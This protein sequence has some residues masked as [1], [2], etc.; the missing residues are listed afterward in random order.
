VDSSIADGR[1][2]ARRSGAF[3]L[4]YLEMSPEH[5]S[6]STE[7]IG[8]EDQSGTIGTQISFGEIPA[9]GTAYGVTAA[10]H[11]ISKPPCSI[12]PITYSFIDI[13]STGTA[14]DA[15][16]SG[17]QNSWESD[18]GWF[19][20]DISAMGFNWYGTVENTISV[21]T[22]GVITFGSAHFMYGGSE[23]V[24]CQGEEESCSGLNV[25]GVLAV[26]WA[27][28]N[29][30]ATADS[31]VYYSVMPSGTMFVAQWDA[32][33]YWSD[34]ER[35]DVRNTF[36]A[37]LKKN[38]DVTFSYADMSPEH[39]S[40]STESIGF[41]DNSG[42]LG[43]QI[44][45]GEI[46]TPGTSYG[47]T[48]ACHAANTG[49]LIN[50][51]AAAT[52]V[53]IV[54][55]SGTLIGP[56][57]WTSGGQNSWASDDGWFDVDISAMG[58]FSWYGVR[59]TT[60]SAGTNGVITFGTNHY[61]Y[62]GS[63]PMPCAG[64]GACGDSSGFTADGL[65]VDG[66]LGVFW[67]DVNPGGSTADGAG[68]Y[69]WAG[70]GSTVITWNAVMYW[71]DPERPDVTNTFQ[72]V[73][74]VSGDISLNYNDMNS[75]QLSWSAESIG[76]EDQTGSFG[77]QVRHLQCVWSFLQHSSGKHR[78][79]PLS[80]PGNAPVYLQAHPFRM[81]GTAAQAARGRTLRRTMVTMHCDHRPT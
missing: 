35:P 78:H 22:N 73:L 57:N 12:G 56:G 1:P 53:D 74:S 48:A 23:P 76:F 33:M 59:E 52:W 63:E 46:P 28:I 18:D 64:E 45:F 37:V 17:G 2:P 72:A 80:L 70:T 20:V 4:Q 51:A 54:S 69:T 65:N 13:S 24:P 67:S 77:Y 39:L 42:S 75:E 66:A 32:V 43:V 44:S 16:T 8:F 71:S 61:M 60:I 50:T 11:V 62:G 30:G 3:K 15:W 26:Y 40:W 38:G 58:G 6:W 34:P 21:G 5:L 14:I 55:S 29:P 31:G 49:C 41:E 25:D 7:S 36:Q 27:D 68:V 79:F 10:C 47:I 19:D 81:S 9:P